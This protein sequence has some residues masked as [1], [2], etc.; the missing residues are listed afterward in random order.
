MRVTTDSNVN[1]GM[2]RSL[3]CWDLISLAPDDSFLTLMT[4][5]GKTKWGRNCLLSGEQ[6][7]AKKQR[8][9]PQS[10]NSGATPAT[11]ALQQF[12][13]FALDENSI[14]E[15]TGDV[16]FDMGEKSSRLQPSL[17]SLNIISKEANIEV[18]NIHSVTRG[19]AKITASY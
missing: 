4:G 7:S 6:C 13:R 11:E 3:P 2:K 14:P 16:S 15:L 18:P 1:S 9:C 12:L 19:M 10:V 8:T 5:S 17:Y